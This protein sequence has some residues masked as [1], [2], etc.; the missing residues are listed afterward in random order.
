MTVI[1]LSPGVVTQTSFVAATL[2]QPVGHGFEFDAGAHPQ[3]LRFDGA[4]AGIA[5]VTDIDD[6]LTDGRGARTDGPLRT[7]PLDLG[8]GKPRDPHDPAVGN[9]HAVDAAGIACRPPH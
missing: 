5:S 6:G 9:V 2:D 4:D 8:G 7:V 1:D 3:R